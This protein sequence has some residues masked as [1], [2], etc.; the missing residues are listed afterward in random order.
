MITKPGR[1]A[2]KARSV[3]KAKA[4]DKKDANA[5]TGKRSAFKVGLLGGMSAGLTVNTCLFPL[6]TLKTRLQSRPVGAAMGFADRS[7][8]RGLYR[9]FFIDTMGTFPGTG[10]FMATYEVLK[11]T[12]ALHPTLC[13]AGASVAGSL[14]TAPCDAMKQRMQVDPAATVR[15]ELRVAFKSANPIKRLFVGYPQFLIRDLPFDAIQ[16]TSFEALK[17]WHSRTVEP[18]RRRTPAE[19]AWLGG[20]AGA[21]TGLLTTPL[22]VARTAEVCA[23]RAGLS[24]TG[25]EC[26]V[27]MVKQG[28]PA[29]LLRGSLPRMVEISLGGV[30]YFSALEHTKRVLGYHD[31]LS[32]DDGKGKVANA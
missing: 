31:P 19:L 32:G 18:G 16:M 15:G 26:L 23:M 28:G 21:I 3:A 27:Q 13:A 2:T 22:D 1:M 11:A 10:L 7:I 29:V 6:N 30:L 20:V 5:K 12:G 9:G 8:L 4:T 17:R 25:T 24:C 14:F